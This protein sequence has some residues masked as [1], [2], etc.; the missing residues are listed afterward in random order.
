MALVSSLLVY[1]ISDYSVPT[2]RET[3]HHLKESRIG[4]R[5][6]RED[7]KEEM[8]AQD[9]IPACMYIMLQ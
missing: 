4:D 9:I 2:I 1:K 7:R 3:F 5:K 6:P 8:C